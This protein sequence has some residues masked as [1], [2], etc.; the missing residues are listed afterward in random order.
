[1]YNSWQSRML[2]YIKGKEH[3]RIMLNSVLNGPLVYGTIE[4]DGVTRLK[5]YEELSNKEKLQDDCDLRATNIVLQ[6]TELSYQERECKLYNEFDK[7]ASVK[8][9]TLHEYYMRFA[10]LMN[11]INIIGMTM[12]QVYVNTKFLNG[13]QPEWSKFMTTVKLA[14]SSQNAYH[15]TA[16][17]QHPQ[18]EFPQLDS[19]L[20]IPSSLPRDDPITS[21]NKAIAF[22]NTTF[23][24]RYPPTNNQLMT[25]SNPRN[26]AIVQDGR[27]IVQQVQGR[28]SQ[29]FVGNGSKSN[30]IEEHMA[31]QCTQPKRPRNSTWFK[32]KLMLVEAQESGQ[33]LDEEQ[34]AFLADP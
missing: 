7:F 22:L 13:L 26:Q 10:Q 17:S 15:T 24:L 1:M 11:D 12:H 31:R 34:L 30:V 32:K 33:V 2:L 8:G 6:G 28:Q 18:P 27:V 9:E 14:K 4:V 16:I 29:S 25:S 3:G 21:L 20:A 23:A 19:G 5:T